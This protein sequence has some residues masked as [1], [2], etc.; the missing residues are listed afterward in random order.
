M[1]L[2]GSPP[3]R[4]SVAQARRPHQAHPNERRT[5]RRCHGKAVPDVRKSRARDRNR[6]PKQP[7]LDSGPFVPTE[8]APPLPQ[9]TDKKSQATESKAQT[10]LLR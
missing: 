1:R 3:S 10:G 6:L 8:R 7:I 5:F 9:P 4:R 2:T